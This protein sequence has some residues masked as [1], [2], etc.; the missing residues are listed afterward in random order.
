MRVNRPIENHCALA[1]NNECGPD[2]HISLGALWLDDTM[3]KER[4]LVHLA[5][6]SKPSCV[7]KSFQDSTFPS[8]SDSKFLVL[9]MLNV[10]NPRQ[11]LKNCQIT[12]L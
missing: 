2:Y 9:T 4:V 6:G 7:C 8:V 5:L 3:H 10:V 1:G 12:P 11:C